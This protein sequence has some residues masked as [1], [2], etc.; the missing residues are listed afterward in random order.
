MN[1]NGLR[2]QH[3]NT[4]KPYSNAKSQMYI[5]HI[6]NIYTTNAPN[7]QTQKMPVEQ[8]VGN[9]PRKLLMNR[10]SLPIQ[11]VGWMEKSGT[12]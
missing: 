2:R 1:V 3:T 9:S 10:I 7:G 4:V 6:L 8:H 12:Q 11:Q 5:Q